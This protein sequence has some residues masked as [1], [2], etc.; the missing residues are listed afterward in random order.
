MSVYFDELEKKAAGRNRN[1]KKKTNEQSECAVYRKTAKKNVFN[2]QNIATMVKD[3]IEQ[4]SEHTHS[5]SHLKVI[6]I[7][8]LAIGN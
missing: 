4:C 3:R 1:E 7:G 2:T 6:F 5:H 8:T